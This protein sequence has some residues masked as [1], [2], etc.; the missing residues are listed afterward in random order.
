M[1]EVELRLAVRRSTRPS[2][3][4]SPPA[5]ASPCAQNPAATKKP[6]TSVSPRQNSLSGV[7]ASGPLMSFVTVTSSIAGTRAPALPGDLLEAVPVLLEQP[8]V[9][10]RRDRV[11]PRSRPGPGRGSLAARSRPSPGRRPPRGSRRA[12]RG[13]AS[14]AAGCRASRSRNGCVTRYSWAIGTIGTRTPASRPISAAN[15]PPALTTTSASMSPHSVSTPRTRPVATSIPVTRVWVKIR[16]PPSRARRRPARRSAATDRGS[17]RSAGRHAPSTPSVDI[18]GKS[19]CASSAEISSSGSPN[20][21][22]HAAWRRSSSIRSG[23]H[24]SR[25]PPHS[26]QP[27]SKS[28]TPRRAAGRARRSASSSSSATPIRAAGRRA[29]PS[30]RSSREVSS[31]AVDQHDVALAQLRQVVGDRRPA[32]TAADDHEAR[33]SGGSARSAISSRPP[34][35]RTSSSQRSK[36][37]SAACSRSRSKCLA[38]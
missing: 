22:A 19:S 18:S 2:P 27:G 24:A 31:V 36:R 29:R 25:I 37:G 13:R 5:P 28:R 35:P 23:V 30:G 12:G 4:R 32:D 14:S 21:C 11:E 17:R 26:V 34:R 20:V 10:V 3:C 15:M 16:Q 6:A 9:E 1:P 8:P 7:N 33:R 38:A